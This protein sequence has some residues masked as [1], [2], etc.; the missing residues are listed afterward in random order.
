MNKKE[1]KKQILAQRMETKAKLEVLRALGA[2]KFDRQ[3]D[4]LLDRLNYLD[5]LLGELDK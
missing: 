5:R 2:V 4:K 3:I 1:L